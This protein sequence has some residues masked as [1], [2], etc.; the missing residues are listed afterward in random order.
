MP[1]N[2]GFTGDGH[3]K[4]LRTR[5]RNMVLTLATWNVRTM[6]QAGKM[7]EV[8]EEVLRYGLDVVALQEV[9]WKGNGRIDKKNYSM[10]YSGS[11]TR[12]GQRG[13]GFIINSK[14]KKSYLGFEPLGERMCK[15]RLKGRF[16]NLFIISAYAPTED[17]NEEEKNA[18]YDELDRECSKI[19]KYDVLILLGDFNA[20]IGRENFL[21]HVAGKHSLHANTNLNDHYLVKARLRERLSNVECAKGLEKPHWDIEKLRQP[22][23]LNHYQDT[24]NGKLEE[25]QENL[26]ENN[27][28]KRKW[29]EIKKAIKETA[30]ETIRE[31]KRTRNEEW[32]DD[33]CRAEI[34]RKNTDRLLMIQRKTRQNYEKYR[35]SRRQAKKTLRKKKKAHL[36]RYMERIEELSTQN[37]CRKLYQA[38]KRMTKEFQPRTNSCKDKNGK[39]IGEEKKVLE[40][41]AEYFA[42]LLNVQ[43]RSEENEENEEV[44]MKV[45][46]EITMPLLEEVE[47]AVKRQRNGRAPGEDQLTAELLKY[48]GR[49]LTK[50]IHSLICEIWEREEIPEE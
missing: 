34:D 33:E 37:E 40:R 7:M 21:Q 32:F 41:W 20:K 8:A 35:E 30:R 3:S 5:K 46:P 18:F 16:K 50:K 44:H 42:E 28:V 27:V 24:L 45:D 38:T 2:D 48:G 17:A 25:E 22:E 23:I 1:R 49:A 13:T 43:E 26:I 6:L 12:T 36:K 19:P 29:D 47:E 10:F 14:M 9:R 39:L 15:L 31:K 4:D 11:E